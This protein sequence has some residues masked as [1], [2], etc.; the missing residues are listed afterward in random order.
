MRARHSRY[1]G[2]K[3]QAEEGEESLPDKPINGRK[4]AQPQ[5]GALDD[6]KVSP[7]RSKKR[8]K[9]PKARAFASAR[10]SGNR[11]VARYR[12]IALDRRRSADSVIARTLLAQKDQ[13]APRSG[14]MEKMSLTR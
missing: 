7:A 5:D 8:D 12:G 13:E 4:L 14:A 9:R 1:P 3:L 6:R 11:E 10:D 2:E